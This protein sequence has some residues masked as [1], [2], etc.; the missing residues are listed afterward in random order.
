MIKVFKIHDKTK[1]INTTVLGIHSGKDKKTI[2]NACYMPQYGFS[3]TEDEVKKHYTL[4][5]KSNI[6]ADEYFITLEIN[7]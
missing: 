5:E 1:D 3:T 6:S 4:S 2:Y 7:D